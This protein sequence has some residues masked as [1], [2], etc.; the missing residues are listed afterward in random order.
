VT[1]NGVNHVIIL[2]T[3][4]SPE[5]TLQADDSGPRPGQERDVHVHYILSRGTVEEQTRELINAKAAAQQAV[6]DKEAPFKSVE[7]VMAKAV[8]VQIEVARRMIEVK[9]EPIGMQSLPEVEE[10]AVG[11]ENQQHGQLTMFEL[12]Q[13]HGA[14]PR[15][16][17]S[18][19]T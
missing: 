3:E 7:E 19:S 1:I 10:E 4:W 6:F 5:T 14:Q 12:F 2:N 18:G 13:R 16:Q 17:S 15:R 11:S 9:R 8:S